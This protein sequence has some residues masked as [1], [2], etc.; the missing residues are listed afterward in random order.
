RAT[1]GA[2]ARRG[3]AKLA[4]ALLQLKQS[5]ALFPPGAALLGAARKGGDTPRAFAALGLLLGAVRL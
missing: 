2:H 3:R 4:A 5:R 1:C